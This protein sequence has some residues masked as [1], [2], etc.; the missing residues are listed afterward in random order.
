MKFEPKISMEI[1]QQTYSYKLLESLEKISKTFSQRR[2]AKELKIS[3]SVLNRRIKNN[4]EKLGFDLIKIIG[5]K[6]YLTDE[7][8]QILKQ[9]QKYKS[10]ASEN[11]KIA[12]V[13]GHII[14][15]L[16]DS[17]SDE[18][19]FDIDIYSSSDINAYKLAKKGF[20]DLLALDDP[21]IA[22][23][24]DLDFTPIA[25]DYL[26]LVSNDISKKR[27]NNIKD[28]NDLNFISVNGSSQR[29]AWN[30]LRENNIS[31]KII[32]EVRS[33]FDAFKIVKN[34]QNLYTFLNASYF[35]GNNVL[36]DETKH[37]ISLI[38]INNSK[39]EI[40]ALITCIL[41]NGQ[42]LIAKQGFTPIKP[43]KIPK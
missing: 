37:V 14:T 17:I 39:K 35:K 21:Q 4:Q 23:L 20:V 13:G 6:S 18:L 42:K 9:Y 5:S 31:F 1:N 15:G 12:I 38:Q 33:E 43:W 8:I 19:P 7:A 32:Q 34:S 16:L 11:D 10:R 40:N 29:L 22:F 25:Y 27:I 30:T 26:V 41:G 28:L 24:N 36:K 3:H 2:A